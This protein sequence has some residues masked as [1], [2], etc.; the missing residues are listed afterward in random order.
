[1]SAPDP[2][3]LE[4]FRAVAETGSATSAAALLNSTQPTVTR[5]IAELERRCGFALFERVRLGMKL[6]PEG[7]ILLETV[8]RNFEGLRSVQ[9]AIDAIRHGA[10]GSLSGSALPVVG[11]G[12]LMELIGGFLREH[13]TVQM[14]IAASAPHVMF[15]AL[16][17]DRIDFGVTLGPA[18]DP[19][20][21]ETVTISRSSL[22]LAVNA[23]HRLA[24]ARQARFAEL[25]GE[26]F[27]QLFAPHNIRAAVDMM[28]LN[29]GIRPALM[30]ETTTQR[31]AVRL[32][33]CTDCVTFVDSHAA[34]E[35]ASPAIVT[36]PLEPQI[37]WDINLIYRRERK[38]SK[39]F[40]SFLAWLKR[41]GGVLPAA[42]GHG[43]SLTPP[44]H[45]LIPDGRR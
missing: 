38:H 14:K 37:V 43:E 25:G 28:I 27:V 32:V 5:A 33:E 40:Q 39:T 22:M 24:G 34:A 16:A 4:I 44:P 3:A 17:S 15:D 13:P 23:G 1:M 10:Q 9:N 11:E 19:G 8:R 7:Q 31:A 36:V 6:T 18:P 45:L 26:K 12:V 35:I 30:H 21:Y 20:H 29:S 41:R 42:R 2:R